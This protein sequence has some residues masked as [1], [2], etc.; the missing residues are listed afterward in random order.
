MKLHHQSLKY[1]SVALLCI[2]TIWA[3]IFYFALLDEVYD[4]LDDG[5]DN[6]R[7][8]IIQRA[9]QDTSLL[10]R[11]E[12]RESNYIIHSISK[13]EALQQKDIFEDTLMYMQNEDDL[14][15]VRILTTAF[16]RDER[17]YH[18]RVMTSMV[19]EDDLIES[20]F[21]GLLWLYLILMAVIIFVN[22][23][24][25]KK[26]WDPFYQI[27]AQLRG[28]RVGTDPVPA[29]V[30]TN[31]TEFKQLKIAVEQL[32]NHTL[33]AFNSQKQFTENAAH[34]L[35][36]PLAASINKLE[37][38][39]ERQQVDEV[40]VK[41]LAEVI[42]ILQRLTRFNR[43]L[44]LLSRIENRQYLQGEE[45]NINGLVKEEVENINDFARHKKVTFKITS[46][47]NLKPSLNKDLAR[48]LISNLI[49][50]AV[51]HN[52]QGGMVNVEITPGKFLICNTGSEIPL[53]KGKVF[54]RF[55]KETKNADNTGLGLAIVKAITETYL[56]EVSYTFNGKHCFA[57]LFPA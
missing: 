39:L 52:I 41:Q 47:E 54:Q 5:L 31:V 49:K 20:F 19:E 1:L 8:L 9:L 16:Q 44:L 10:S 34:E 18:L 24:V 13:H 48:I 14:E 11:T 32:F 7:Q 50:N 3:V 45:V 6:T 2:I 27:L 56:I 43:S 35:Q 37:I 53:Q 46:K 15:P 21:W 38:L 17:Y 33:K 4:S 40:Q 22:N 55:F 23:R 26:L 30:V 29:A 42:E 36:T 12:F 51:V 28:Y 25:L 57:L